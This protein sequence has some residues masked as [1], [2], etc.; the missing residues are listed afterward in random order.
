VFTARDIS[1]PREQSASLEELRPRCIWYV[2]P[3]Y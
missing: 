2:A 1:V 3:T